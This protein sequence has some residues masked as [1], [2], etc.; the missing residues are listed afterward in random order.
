MR[1][2][3]HA[4]TCGYPVDILTPKVDPHNTI[5]L[6]SIKDSWSR[7]EVEAFGKKCFDRGVT[8]GY[9]SYPVLYTKPLS[10]DW[11]KENL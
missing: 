11:I 1:H 5:T 7:E 6:H 3:A 2:C 4:D 8:K 9:L 10:K